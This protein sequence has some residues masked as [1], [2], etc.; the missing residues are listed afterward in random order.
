MVMLKTHFLAI[1][2][3]CAK[4]ILYPTMSEK[5][6]GQTRA[7][8]CAQNLSA[9]CYLDLLPTDKVLVYDTTSCHDDHLF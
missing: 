8:A 9:D 1:M 3:I 5:V 6:M 4:L 7:E 2:I